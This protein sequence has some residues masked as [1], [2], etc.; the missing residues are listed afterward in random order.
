MSK[1]G[2]E[3]KVEMRDVIRTEVAQLLMKERGLET[4]VRT[5]EGVV[6]TVGETDF[7]IRVI[8][9]KEKVKQGDVVDVIEAL[10]DE[11][12]T[13]AEDEAGEDEPG[14]ELEEAS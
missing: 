11:T 6:L 14:E 7:V 5:K 4:M 8:Q 1:E 10:G 12:E 3:K 9:K 2:K 13:G